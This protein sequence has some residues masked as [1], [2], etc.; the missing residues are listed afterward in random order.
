M[1]R[2]AAAV[3]VACVLLVA[4]AA[5]AQTRLALDPSLSV[6]AG[7]DDNLFL[8]PTLS[9]ATATTP[10]AD[11][12]VD[13]HPSLVAL[14][15]RHDHALALTADYLERV[16]PANQDLR[17][18]YLRLD[19]TSAAWHRLR[20]LLGG[21]YEHYEAD[22][23]PDNTFDLGG[24][25]AALRFVAKSAWLEAR[26]RFDARG[27]TSAVRAGQLDL[28]QRASAWLH[29]RLHR[30][31][32][33]DA[34]YSFLHVA[35]NEPTAALDR[36]R[37]DVGLRL[38]PVSWLTLDAGYGIFYQALPN[39][40]EPVVVAGVSGPGGPRSDLAHQVAAA[41]TVR[42]L[43]WLELFARY[44]LI[45][46]TSDASPGNYRRDQV[47]GGLAVGW[48]FAHV[49]LPS[50][51]PLRP[52]V[53]GREVTFRARAR[54]GA[55]VA[56]V[57]DWNGWAPQPLAPAG[58][59]RFEATYTLPPGRHAWALS[60]DGNVVTPPEAAAYVDDGFGGRNAVVEV[61]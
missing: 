38:R 9:G 56:V 40:A 13:I 50:P 53:V 18:L 51:P 43:A 17:D 5:R 6:A 61:R 41:V 16:T 8:D 60:V 45:V 52:T 1:L 20:L 29:G 10:R 23:F 59:D 22:L 44:D 39:G 31:V 55:V 37:V 15:A 33:L 19:W 49:R 27:Y 46:S 42:P 2:A 14:V 57:G 7:W 11:A 4:S 36:H 12:V 25:E 28:E 26:Y 34:G 24:G 30:V 54:A 32:A 47:L 35:S 58:G 48:D 21:L 3:A